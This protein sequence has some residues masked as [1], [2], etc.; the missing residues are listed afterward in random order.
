MR[1]EDG[2]GRKPDRTGDIGLVFL[3]HSLKN[4]QNSEVSIAYCSLAV[5]NL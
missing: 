3:A 4:I 2:G 1:S 5:H